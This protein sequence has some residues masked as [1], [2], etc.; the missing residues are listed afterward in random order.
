MDL[1]SSLTD[2]DEPLSTMVTI[3]SLFDTFAGFLSNYDLLNKN[4]ITL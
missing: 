2:N 3:S 4:I 1:R